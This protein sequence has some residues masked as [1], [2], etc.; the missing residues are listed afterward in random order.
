[1]L[2]AP[3]LVGQDRDADAHRWAI[4]RGGT[5]LLILQQSA[6]DP[7]FGLDVNYW[8]HPWRGDDPHPGSP[9]IDWLFGVQ[10]SEQAEPGAAAD[11]G[12]MTA[13]PGS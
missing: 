11:G 2:G 5:G 3:K 8:L 1:M 12:G 9:F 10:G 4:W 7:Q 6:Y 13:F